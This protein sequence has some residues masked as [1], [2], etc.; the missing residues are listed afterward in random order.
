MRQLRSQTPRLFNWTAPLKKPGNEKRLS[1]LVN[2]WADHFKLKILP[3]LPFALLMPFFQAILASDCNCSNQ[4]TRAS[5]F[6]LTFMEAKEFSLIG[7]RVS[8]I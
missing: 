5:L 4:A 2:G 7:M 3:S 6:S 8:N 1:G